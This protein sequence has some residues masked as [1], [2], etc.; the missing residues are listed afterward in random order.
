LSTRLCHLGNIAFRTGR[1]LYFNSVNETIK[2][3]PEANKL[4][5]RSYRAPFALPRVS[6][7]PNG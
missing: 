2:D 4:L 7:L 1:T 6:Q 5:G 3:D